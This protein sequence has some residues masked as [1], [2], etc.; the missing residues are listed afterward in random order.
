MY[1]ID[2]KGKYFILVDT[3]EEEDV[4]IGQ[5]SEEEI[6]EKFLQEHIEA[7]SYYGIPPY[8]GSNK[9]IHER[10]NNKLLK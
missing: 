6:T 4:V 1:Q 9:E 5:M 8:C 7:C 10:I 2:Y 3:P